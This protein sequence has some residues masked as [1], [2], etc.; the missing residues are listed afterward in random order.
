MRRMKTDSLL[1][2]LKSLK[3]TIAEHYMV[4]EIELF[5][6]Y[7][8]GEQTE[9]S[10]LDLLVEFREGADLFH[11]V[12]LTQFL[13][14]ELELNVDVVTKRAL[15]PGVRESVLRETQLV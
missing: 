4:K 8:R 15:R 1:R 13:E 10:D 6:S 5:G 11:L 3:S 2:K 12:G 9:T 14:E 7:G